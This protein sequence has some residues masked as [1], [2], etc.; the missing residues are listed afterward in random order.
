MA[1]LASTFVDFA[2]ASTHADTPA[3][4]TVGAWRAPL[5]AVIATHLSLSSVPAVYVSMPSV[6]L[7]S[8]EISRLAVSAAE[9]ASA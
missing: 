9:T 8:G 7:T 5:W 2:V 6:T 1:P 4:S 3:R